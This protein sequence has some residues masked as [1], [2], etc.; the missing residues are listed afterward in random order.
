MATNEDDDYLLFDL[1]LCLE[2]NIPI[3]P[4]ISAASD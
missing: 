1:S 4:R 2:R 3:P